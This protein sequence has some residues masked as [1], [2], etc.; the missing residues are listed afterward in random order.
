M[1]SAVLPTY[2]PTEPFAYGKRFKEPLER[3]LHMKL[4][5]HT[6]N[7]FKKVKLSVLII[8]QYAMKTCGGMDV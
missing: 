1:T 2:L 3:F 5:I 4:K 6:K 7:K 8:K